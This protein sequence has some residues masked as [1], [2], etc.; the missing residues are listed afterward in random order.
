MV[1]IIIHTKIFSIAA[2]IDRLLEHDDSDGNGYLD[3]SEFAA[4]RRLM[5]L[6]SN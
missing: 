4:S 5:A 2:N 6:K 3:Y 1:I